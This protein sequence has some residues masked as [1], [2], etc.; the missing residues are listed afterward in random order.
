[1]EKYERFKTALEPVVKFL[2]E[3]PETAVRDQAMIKLQEV[4]FWSEKLVG[5]ELAAAKKN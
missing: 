5:D 1:M 2:L 4:A 3:F